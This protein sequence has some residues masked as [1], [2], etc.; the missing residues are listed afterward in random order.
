MKVPSPTFQ[1]KG[2]PSFGFLFPLNPQGDPAT[3]GETERTRTGEVTCRPTRIIDWKHLLFPFLFFV[4]IAIQAA[5]GA[6]TV[7]L[8]G[9]TP[10]P[11]AILSSRAPTFR[12]NAS[13]GAASYELYVRDVTDSAT[14]PLYTYPI[15]GTNTTFQPY[16]GRAYKW[17]AGA[18]SGPNQTG[19]FTQAANS[20]WFIS[21]QC[22]LLVTGS[23]SLSPNPVTAGN[24]VT[25]GYTVKNNGNGDSVSSSNR[26]Q[27]KVGSSTTTLAEG[28]FYLPAILAGASTNLSAQL[29][30]PS[31]ATPGSYSVHTILDSLNYNVQP[32]YA[33]DIHSEYD[34]LTISAVSPQSFF[35]TLVTNPV[36]GGSIT[37]SP[38]PGGNGKYS[39]STLVN[40]TV[41]P[42]AGY[43]FTGWQF[44]AG[45]GSTVSSV[46]NMTATVGMDSDRTVTAVFSQTDASAP[47][48][49]IANPSDGQ[50]FVNSSITVS[51]TATDNNLGNNGVYS[52]TI[53]GVRAGG[54][55][56]SGSGT[57][58][59]SGSVTLS[60]ATT[61]IT[62]V[63]RD[64]TVS[65]N[66][67]TK[68]I[69]VNYQ[70]ALPPVASFFA[71]DSQ[72]V[73]GKE[74]V[75][76]ASGSS[77]TSLNY[78][79][80]SDDGQ[81]ISFSTSST[82]R[83]SFGS[84]GTRVVT[85][86]VKDSYNQV[87]STSRQITVQS[88]NIGGS[89]GS[90]QSFSKDPVNLATGNYIY[91]HT[92]LRLPGV[93][94]PFEFKRFYNSKFADQ[95]GRPMGFG[96]THSYNLWL[97]NTTTNALITFGDGHVET[98][99]LQPD[100]SYLPEAGVFDRLQKNGDGTWTL[101]TKAQTQQNFNAQGRLDSI[102][103]KNGNRLA[104]TYISSQLTSITDTAGRSVMF[105]ND[106]NGCISSLLDSIGRTIRY[107][108]DGQTNLVRVVDANNRTNKFDYDSAH[109]LTDAF[110]AKGT[111]YVHNDYD[112]ATRVVVSQLDAYSKPTG[113]SYD[114]TNR[115]T[116]VTNSLGKF[117]KHSFDD[118]L[119]VTNIVDEAGH[120]NSFNYDTNR[121]L[122]WMK[123]KNGNVTTYGY[124]PRGNVTNKTDAYNSV[125]TIEYD[126]KNNPTRRVDALTNIT[127]FGY[128]GIG[129]LT[130]TTNAEGHVNLVSYDPRGL[131]L[132]LTD[133]RGFRTTN[134]FD[135]QANLVAVVNA[136]GFTNRFEH[137]GVGRRIRQIDSNNHTNTVTYDNNDNVI[138]TINALGF[139][140]TFIYDENNNRISTRDP[141]NATTTNIFDLKDRPVFV[142]NALAFS[143][144]SEFDPL[145]RVVATTD[146]RTN[147][148]SAAFDD[149]GNRV[150][151]T[152]AIGEVMRFTFDPNGNQTSIIEPGGRVTTNTFDALNRPVLSINAATNA[153]GTG[154]DE[155]GR[156]TATTNGIG[157][158][159]LFR[160]D[161]IGRL[162]NVV[163]AVTNSISF[164]YDENGN[165][166]RVIDPRGNI[167]TNRFNE[168]NQLIEQS[169]P[170]GN[171]FIFLYD[172]VGNLT[173]TVTPN[174]A[175]I[176]RSYDALN[177]LTNI[178]YPTGP[179]VT[180]GYD[181]VGNRT[182][183][184]DSVGT[185][186]WRYDLLNRL[187][188]VTDPY[189]QTVTNGFDAA[190]NRVVLGYPGNLT[191][192]YGYDQLNRMMA[193]TNWL[194]GVITYG[195]N[196]RGSLVNTTNANGTSTTFAYEA[197]NRIVGLTNARPDASV[198]AGYA[199]TLDGI[200][201]H[202]QSPKIQP[203]YP[204]LPDQ[205]NTYAYDAD[206]RLTAVDG[207]IVT[208][209]NNG[210]LTGIGVETFGYD[211]ENRLVRFTLTNFTGIC[212]YDGG[213]TRLAA[214]ANGISRRYVLDR[215][216]ALSQVLVETDT[217]GVALARYVF[218]LGLTQ[219]ITPDE[220][221]ST[222]H[223]DIRGSTVAMTDAA[224]NLTDGYAYDSFGVLA[225]RDGE[226]QQPFR[227]LGRY[228]ILDDGSGLYFARARHFSPQLGRFLT[229][230]PI[231]GKD[232]DSQSLNRYIYALNTP[233]RLVDT[234]GLSPKEGIIS[235][236]ADA[237]YWDAFEESFYSSLGYKILVATEVAGFAAT[238]ALDVAPIVLELRA[239]GSLY[240]A[241]RG[242][243]VIQS[244]GRLGSDLTRQHVAD[245]ASKLESTGWTITGGGGRLPE[246][247]LAGAGGR[248]LGS[249]YPDITATK[250]GVTLRVN[251]VDTY[252]DG[253][254]P[255][256]REAANAER[257]RSQAPGD[258][259]LLVPKPKP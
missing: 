148:T 127:L 61:T 214:T 192:R 100:S 228:G 132:I 180:F 160:Y 99:I 258:I 84:T 175:S 72:P 49:T 159:T 213:G 244:G 16:P 71:S 24:I 204:I 206:N 109:Q 76:D 21:A 246:E 161:R 143:V 172:S 17:N 171:T 101:I 20:L 81:S 181:E 164:V 245:T 234:T 236:S 14:G 74:V 120:T 126:A 198:I 237:A 107:E 166:I 108:Y 177:R 209:D 183:M 255:T 199:L 98:H 97:T 235:S 121:N 53:N 238:V 142:T 94:F 50:T 250:N 145:D 140:N 147:R 225:N 223:F 44:N 2:S 40:L 134:A 54:D 230:D 203:L 227:Y 73:T 130:A 241:S 47:A 212:T 195:Y 118:R 59:W 13:A 115:M 10:A 247:Y 222:Y 78:A 51:G 77:G 103:D 43:A 242:T 75:F 157:Q 38:A 6:F 129:N 178:A 186:T 167:W 254:T 207:R 60:Q 11:G 215:L 169:D 30:I 135:T 79:W 174:G 116:W 248:R 114:F 221:A 239:A 90:G 131:P 188:S 25:I 200:G 176:G 106:A 41:A 218:G 5:P 259:L 173:N 46:P 33:N 8:P 219:R 62:V 136:K 232:S 95:T 125:T 153:S 85:L 146:P 150:A 22:D 249:S 56:A 191:I 128:N 158:V 187:L 190:G 96:W 122:V 55:T 179:P 113:F 12:W 4:L 1:A 91:E 63:A 88:R 70:P 257:I 152:N 133:A 39:A 197:A 32:D 149:V 93:G 201:N 19:T 34:I 220:T 112:P 58:T 144:A 83:F 86:Q 224:A 217:N 64:N 69:T 92:D 123:D 31:G 111:R 18:Y 28:Y 233:L 208:H 154:Y 185:T 156:V 194:G 42:G 162:T 256:A 29:T 155:L 170:Q 7:I 67:V 202:I 184:T 15:N 36:I 163:S 102:V 80:S 138:L 35:L 117:A 165:R 240:L 82:A 216:S 182:N 89:G 66:A 251:T 226:S 68:T 48:L 231:T 168:L 104:L 27:I 9:S 151:I 229:K 211:Y 193:L 189:G 37:A 196:D 3:A 210:N 141:R 52:V 205:T 243:A 65:Q 139:T 57:A 252:A 45:S 119:L 87:S 253:F 110:D 26:I 23:V 137:D 124:D 105:T